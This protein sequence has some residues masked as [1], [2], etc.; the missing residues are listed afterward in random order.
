M[1]AGE[2]FALNEGDFDFEKNWNIVN[3]ADNSCK[4]H[5]LLNLCSI[6]QKKLIFIWKK[7]FV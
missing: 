3:K 6:N 2:L 1:R 7:V 5:L 4:M